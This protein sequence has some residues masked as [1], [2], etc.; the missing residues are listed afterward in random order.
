VIGRVPEIPFDN[1]IFRT[2]S[3]ENIKDR[4]I[5]KPSEKQFKK[6]NM[7]S[8]E[9]DIT[10]K[11]DIT[12]NENQLNNMMERIQK[13]LTTIQTTGRK[14]KLK[15]HNAAWTNGSLIKSPK[16]ISWECL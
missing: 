4:L 16:M 1:K 8:L 3:N 11:N 2:T 10:P 15:K 9:N 12:V 6:T 13:F 14:P 5:H 7:K